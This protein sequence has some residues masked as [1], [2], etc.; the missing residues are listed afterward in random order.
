M[1]PDALHRVIT[2]TDGRLDLATDVL[3]DATITRDLGP[4]FVLTGATRT[5]TAAG[6]TVTGLGT[7]GP[8]AGMTV[9]A[10]FTADGALVT[11][12]AGSTWTFLDAFPMVKGGVFE[13]LR[14]STP[15]LTRKASGDF[16]FTGTLIIT[17]ELA[18]LDLIAAEHPITGDISM[19]TE[20]P[21][22]TELPITPVPKIELY[23][24]RGGSL[25]LGLFTLTGL[26]Y[27]IYGD[28]KL[29]YNIVDMIV[30]SS[31]VVDG[32]I[33]FTAYGKTSTV[34]I[35][36]EI[37]GAGSS[38]LF[39]ADLRDLGR[40]AFSDI[41]AF[42][43]QQALEVP[44][45]FEVTAP[46]VPA[47]V[48]LSVSG[49]SIDFLS[50]TLETEQEWEITTGLRLQAIDLTFR[51]AGSK[52]EVFVSG[53][54]GI[55]TSGTLELATGF[56]GDHTSIGGGLRED[57]PPLSIREVYTDFTGAPADHLPDLVVD[58]FDFHLTLPSETDPLS[59]EAFLDLTGSWPITDSVELVEVHFN[60]FADSD[61]AEFVAGANLII[62]SVALL[63]RASYDSANG[64][65]FEGATRPGQQLPI[66]DLANSLVT[67]Y[68][69]A[70]LPAPL[71]GLTV[72]DLS[73]A[74]ST[75]NTRFAFTA[76][77]RFPIDTT[78]VD[79]SVAID[80][81]AR[82]YGGRIEVTTPS[83]LVLDFDVHFASAAAATRFAISYAQSATPTLKELVGALSPTAAEA[84][85]DGL[86]VGVKDAVLASD[87]TSYA[88]CVD[89][90]A[91]IDL[92]K[93]PVVGSLLHG[94]QIMGFDPL[95]VIAAT[96]PIAAAEV[97]E[98]GKLLPSTIAP[99]PAHDLAEGLTFDGLL[100]LGAFEQAVTLPVATGSG[101]T[102]PPAPAQPA[103]NVL[104]RP[105]QT[106]IGPLHIER[107]GLSYLHEPGQPALL[108]VLV[109]ASLTVGGLTL[110]CT[111][112]SA[113]ISLA[114][115][116]AV[117]AFDLAGLGLAYAEGP[118]Q[119]SGAFLKDTLVYGGRTY[120]A[121]NGKAVIKTETF[122][123]GALGSYVQLDEGPSLFV[124]AFL[125][126]PIGGPAFFFVRGIAAGFGY[127][128]RLI[129]PPV[130]KLADFPLVAEATGTQ[131]PGTL[132]T[133]LQRLE[134]DLP[135]SP[136][137]YFL[138]L[139]VHFTSF[140]MIDSFLLL[141][142]GFGHR[143]E[144]N[145]LGV[146]TLVLP[147]P[148]AA[149][150]GVTPIAEIQLALKAT[151]APDDGFF[152]LTAQLTRNS[153]LLSQA[154][155]LTGGFAFVTWFGDEHHGDF[156][157]TVGGYHPHFTVPDHYPLVP[158]LGFTWQVT[159]HL[160]LKGSAYYAMTPSA[161]MAGG[162]LNATYEDGSLRAWFD[163]AL[164]FLI[165]WQPYHYEAAFHLSVGASYTFSFFGTHTITIHVGTDVRFWGP[166]FGGTATIDLSIISFTIIFGSSSGA[167]ATPVEWS[168]FRD[169]QLPTPDK[170]VT[171]LLRGGSG[172]PGVGADLGVVN[173]ADLVLATDTAVPA[174]T[175]Q[176]ADRNLPGA[177]RRFGVAPCGVQDGFTSEHKITITRDGVPAEEHFTFQPIAKDLPAALWG[178]DLLPNLA[179][180]ALVPN[181]LTGY[182]I[183]PVP[184]EEPADPPS[185]PLADLRAATPA[186]TEHHAFDWTPLA[187][188]TAAPGP[189]DPA[190]ATAVR[191]GIAGKLCP[192]L[193]LDLNGFTHADFLDDPQVAAHV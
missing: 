101:P 185:I 56:G 73:A 173:P 106:D 107:V 112:L 41:A 74:F 2:V 122:T 45:G 151:L 118:V 148:D 150:A 115:P 22:A 113:G 144:L 149:S 140:E 191:A 75:V 153:Y 28:P 136:G 124:Y 26:G 187:V 119:I 139:G 6:V 95:R 127:N 10:E 71:A 34:T 49:T 123:V 170:I 46:V 69:A 65:T 169:A 54:F 152:S 182:V 178:D 55:G 177:A 121:Y 5:E 183:R 120:P 94:D 3:G 163:T 29:D 143:F 158:R 172:Q 102:P 80:T 128:R 53:L 190:P 104:W 116:L 189:A 30:R 147:A 146:S 48:V 36:T 99:L 13:T 35:S 68:G 19:F 93:L 125:D 24:P 164:D 111:G 126:Y 70:P 15:V 108:A 103:D 78:E 21:G 58:V 154:C 18:F 171:V 57:D 37:D 134:A 138:A 31:L 77:M 129:A 20:I 33:P 50:V 17:T 39:R 43:G 59:A 61:V 155:R 162:S 186:F 167:D 156:V 165:A 25:D 16:T 97:G 192:G 86:T 175:G 92:S 82:T 131:P 23:G 47:D 137:D 188:F 44:G 88:F 8:F 176:A 76:A 181:L 193:D 141:T 109:D 85:P 12:A 180:P 105:V 42:L 179:K 90:K 1:T 66:G 84:V 64:W 63:L 7:G 159:D 132:A 40:A 38:L 161:L 166:D 51:L 117:P 72:H 27:A 184:P 4:Q 67:R 79:L 168:R 89:L 114:D 11:G 98:V 32:A 110:S 83:G 145:V 87:G 160:V 81:A 96:G 157:L 130:D 100:K 133:E 62:A 14:F 135:P 52:L 60:L 174:R 91:T 142:A 9:T